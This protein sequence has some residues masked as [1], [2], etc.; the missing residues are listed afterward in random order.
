MN[1]YKEYHTLI[2]SRRI[3]R[4]APDR[5]KVLFSF[6]I[7]RKGI[8]SPY[9]VFVKLLCSTSLHVNNEHPLSQYNYRC[10]FPTA[11]EVVYGDE[12]TLIDDLL[13]K[14]NKYARPRV[15]LNESVDVVVD[16]VVI[17]YE[18]LVCLQTTYKCIIV[19]YIIA[20]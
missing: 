19:I 18:D 8:I 15:Q 12:K 3:L 2:I 9:P 6:K 7:C 14:Y 10:S 20:E 4:E 16:L 13:L 11:L 5:Q 17:Q 1:P